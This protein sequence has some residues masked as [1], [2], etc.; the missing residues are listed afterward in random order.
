MQ[1]PNTAP[2]KAR[3]TG[4]GHDTRSLARLHS[5]LAMVAGGGTSTS[6]TCSSSL[7]LLLLLSSLTSPSSVQGGHDGGEE[8]KGNEMR[9][10]R[11]EQQKQQG[12]QPVERAIGLTRSASRWDTIRTWAKLACMNIR[13]PDSTDRYGRGESSAGEV[14]K[15]AASRSF[16]TSKGVVEHAA[17]SAA[18]AAEKAA[19]KTKEK[20][21]RTVSKPGGKPDAEL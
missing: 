7:L 18:K 19:H 13:P 1:R 21:K 11:A 2:R 9:Q 15:E 10:E 16:E 6:P 4:S 14:V 8:A 12:P 3:R 20:A 5:R 17:E